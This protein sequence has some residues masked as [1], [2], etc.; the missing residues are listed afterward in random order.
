MQ[1]SQNKIKKFTPF[2]NKNIICDFLFQSRE[3]EGFYLIREKTA[4]KREREVER[5]TKRES[6][7][8]RERKI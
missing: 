8:G 2:E 3:R 7:R 4:N 5:K 1:P 6:E